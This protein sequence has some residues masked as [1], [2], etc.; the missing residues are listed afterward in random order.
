MTSQS[1]LMRAALGAALGVL[2]PLQALGQTADALTLQEALAIADQRAPTLAQAQAAVDAA[3]GLA[4]QAGLAPNPEARLSLD[5]FAGSGGYGGLDA[6]E[7]T[8]AVGQRIE[9]GGKRQARVAAGE[10][11]IAA[12][13]TRLAIARADIVLDVK[14]LFSNALATREQVLLAEAAVER[15]RGLAAVAQQLVD[16]GREPPLRALRARSAAGEA[17]AE[18]ERLRADDVAARAALASRLGETTASLSVSGDFDSSPISRGA[19]DPSQ[20]LDV[21]LA[22]AEAEAAQ[23]IVRRERAAGASDIDVE[24]GARQFEA[25]GDTAVVFGASIPIPIFNRNQGAIAAANADVRSAA[26]RRLAALAEAVRRIRE[27]EGVLAAAEA[28]VTTLEATATPA[29]AEALSLA[30]AGFEAGRFSLLD[31]LDAEAAYASAQSAL[32]TAR[33]DR[34][35]AAATLERALARENN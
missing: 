25:T 12:S 2:L 19:I 33:R 6:A 29:A 10:A 14:Q 11:E 4:R 34:A 24:I 17:E 27:A 5:D 16:A 35:N 32:I 7:T 20:S 22:E 21:L 30:R 3:R 1:L 26:A 15:A 23:A 8:F 9:L 28:R 13:K 31:V 18:L